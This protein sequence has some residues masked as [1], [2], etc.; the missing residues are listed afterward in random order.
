MKEKELAFDRKKHIPYSKT[1]KNIM[2]KHL[3]AAYGI[4]GAE[5]L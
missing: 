2:L 5:E 1:V 4:D 3:T